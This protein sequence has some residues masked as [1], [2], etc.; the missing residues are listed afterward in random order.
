MRCIKLSNFTHF[1]SDRDLSLENNSFQA[2][3]TGK[4]GLFYSWLILL[5]LT[6]KEYSF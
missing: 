2:V 6:L 4:K 1:F 5:F 3:V